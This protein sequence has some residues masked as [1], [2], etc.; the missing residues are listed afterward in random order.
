MNN[1]DN[2]RL[3]R[4]NHCSRPKRRRRRKKEKNV[5]LTTNEDVLFFVCFRP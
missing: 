3:L 5:Y 1:V 4:I 2:K